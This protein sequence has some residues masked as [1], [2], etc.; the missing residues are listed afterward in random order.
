MEKPLHDFYSYGI[1][2]VLSEVSQSH[3]NELHKTLNSR[4]ITISK[5][6]LSSHLKTLVEAGYVKREEKEGVQV[7]TYT[8]NL[9]KILRIKEYWKRAKSIGKSFGQNK[10]EF[11]SFSESQQVSIVLNLWLEKKLNEIRANVDFRLDRENLD[12]RIALM[13]W[14]SPLLDFA[15]Q[16]LM[17]KCVEDEGYRKRVF[18]EIEASLK[19]IKGQ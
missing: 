14:S 13:F 9:P 3:F 10:K 17:Q 19:R 8:V 1:L 18:K 2:F 4:G 12:K 7:V 11:L 16:W 5:P 6:T 15:E